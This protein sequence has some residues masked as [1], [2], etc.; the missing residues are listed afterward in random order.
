MNEKGRRFTNEYVIY[1]QT[2]IDML[3]QK[4]CWEI[5]TKE[6][7]PVVESMIEKGVATKCDTVEDLAKLI[8]C[9][10]KGLKADIEAHNATT[11]QKPEDRKDPFGRT[12]YEKELKAPF[13]ALRIK[14]VM[15]ETVGGIT[16]DEKCRVTTL[17]GTPVAE[18][19]FAAGAVAFGEHF[20]VGYRS[21]DAYAYAGST[22]ITAGKEAAKL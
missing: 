21:G 15:L 20:G 7:H 16:I 4:A 22:G 11:R 18:G 5:V 8:G 9:D 17:L 12:V 1:T 10:P 3:K 6:L 2:N 14:P 19:L 13:Y